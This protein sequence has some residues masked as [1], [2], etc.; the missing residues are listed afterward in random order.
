MSELHGSLEEEI[1][2]QEKSKC[3]G[4]EVAFR[5]KQA[6]QGGGAE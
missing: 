6:G 5:A 1:P 2:G 4:P 3:K